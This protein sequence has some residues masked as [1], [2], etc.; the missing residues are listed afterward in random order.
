MTLSEGSRKASVTIILSEALA[1]RWAE[2]QSRELRCAGNKKK[3]EEVGLM[4]VYLLLNHC[5]GESP[6]RF[7]STG[8]PASGKRGW[9]RRAGAESKGWSPLEDYS[10]PITREFTK[11]CINSSSNYIILLHEFILTHLRHYTDQ[12][13]CI[14]STSC[15]ILFQRSF[16]C[17]CS[18]EFRRTKGRK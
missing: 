12:C 18:L 14:Q 1:I 15:K 6:R 7:C 5:A 9:N 17:C 10:I 13:P 11:H 3:V 4:I 8:K 16:E 2:S